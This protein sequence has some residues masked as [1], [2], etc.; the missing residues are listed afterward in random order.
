MTKLLSG[1]TLFQEIESQYKIFAPLMGLGEIEN[2]SIGIDSVE[3]KTLIVR[4]NIDKFLGCYIYFSTKL[5]AERVKLRVIED[6]T[7]Y[8]KRSIGA[9][10]YY[11]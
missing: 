5:T 8:L 3:Q 7:H 6:L 11:G 9:T 10:G 4:Y 2:F 1:D